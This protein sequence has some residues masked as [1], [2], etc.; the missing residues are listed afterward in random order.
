M[1][2]TAKTWS[3]KPRTITVESLPVN[4]KPC[5]VIVTVRDE[6]NKLQTVRVGTEPCRL[7]RNGRSRKATK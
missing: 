5:S 2:V 7:E 1:E 4:E 3:E 6:A